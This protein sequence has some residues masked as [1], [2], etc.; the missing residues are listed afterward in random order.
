MK[1]LDI[2]L[3]DDEKECIRV[4][5]YQLKRLFPEFRIVEKCNSA[6]C[7]LLSINR[8]PP[9]LILLDINMPHISGLEL[10]EMLPKGDF[11]IIFTTAY[12]HYALKAFKSSAVDYLLKPIADSELK[13]A[14]LRTLNRKN[15]LLRSKLEFLTNQIKAIQANTVK[16]IMLPTIDGLR[17]ISLRE[18][19]YC[20]GRDIRRL[21]VRKNTQ[22]LHHQ[23]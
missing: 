6:K 21:S 13:E 1:P 20:S 11:D 18:I 10:I 15:N 12:E 7:T 9:D 14:V 4:L 8:S 17:F 2:I 5:E 22:E 23:L 19:I 3:V 16:K